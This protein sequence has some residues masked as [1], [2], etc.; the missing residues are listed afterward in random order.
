MPAAVSRESSWPGQQ[1]AGTEHQHRVTGILPAFWQGGWM[2]LKRLVHSPDFRFPGHWGFVCS[3]GWPFQQIQSRDTLGKEIILQSRFW[4]NRKLSS[5]LL[6]CFSKWL[7]ELS[8]I[9]VCSLCYTKAAGSTQYITVFQSNLNSSLSKD[10]K[11]SSVPLAPSLTFFSFPCLFCSPLIFYPH[12][13]PIV[14]FFL[15]FHLHCHL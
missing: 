13:L 7:S 3:A 14:S 8:R 10:K 12:S 1:T 6:F 9:S 5:I 4:T 15:Q 2:C 11:H